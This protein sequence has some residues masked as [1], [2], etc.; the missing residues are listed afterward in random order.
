MNAILP[1]AG[2]A[3]R[4]RGIPKFLLPFD[5]SGRSLIELHVE[6]LLHVSNI[7]WIPTKPEFIFLLDALNFPADRVRI[8]PAVTENM[9]QTVQKIVDLDPSDYFQLVMPDTYFHGQLPYST[10]KSKPEFVDLACWEIRK[11]QRGKLGQV[12]VENTKVIAI[13]DKNP[14]CEFDH[15]WGALTFNRDLMSLSKTSDPHI[16]FAVK[17]AVDKGLS[18]TCTIIQGKYFDCGTPSEYFSMLSEQD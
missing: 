3:T 16:G 18:V 7:I 4:M 13:E 2:S 9:T 14:N 17:S 1:A 5:L 11:D 15:S 10:M 6:N 8:V 12:K